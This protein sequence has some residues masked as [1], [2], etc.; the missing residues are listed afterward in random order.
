MCQQHISYPHIFWLLMARLVVLYFLLIWRHVVLSLVLHSVRMR[1]RTK[2]LLLLNPIIR[3][4]KVSEAN[5]VTL[6]YSGSTIFTANHVAHS[7]VLEAKR[8]RGFIKTA[9]GSTICLCR[10]CCCS[11]FCSI[12]LCTRTGT[13][14][15]FR[16]V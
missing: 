12:S 11:P 9:Y 3:C 13:D 5:S 10:R 15:N 1:P 14:S 2:I 8:E 16:A 4:C 7:F 6:T